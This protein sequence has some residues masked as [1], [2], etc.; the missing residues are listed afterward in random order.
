MQIGLAG[1]T[2]PAG[3]NG[4]NGNN[5]LM[6]CTYLIDSFAN[7]TNTYYR[8]IRGSDSAVSFISAN[9]SYVV[10]S[11]MENLPIAKSNLKE[12]EIDFT[13]GNFTFFS[14]IEIPNGVSPKF[15]GAG[16]EKTILI[17]G[18]DV[19]DALFAYDSSTTVVFPQWRDMTL[20]GNYRNNPCANAYSA[21]IYTNDKILDGLIDNVFIENFQNDSI[22]LGKIWDWRFANVI[23]EYTHSGYAFRTTGIVGSDMK[24]FGGKV[25]YNEKGFSFQSL[26]EVLIDGCWIYGNQENAINIGNGV[27]G[28]TI[29]NSHF[30]GNGLKVK[31]GYADIFAN[32]PTLN[33]KLIGND[34]DG[35]H[36]N[37]TIGW[38]G[39]AIWRD[40]ASTGA[41]IMGNTVQNYA[42][43]P[44]F[45]FSTSAP[46]VGGVVSG[47]PGYNPRG[48]L[49][50]PFSGNSQYI[51]DN[52]DNATVSLGWTYTNSE[53]CKEV[54]ISGGNVTAVTLNG[55]LTG[56][57]SGSFYLA[58]GNTIKI[59]GSLSPTLIFNCC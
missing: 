36:I 9:A 8:A 42:A 3:A 28:L 25:I 26:S 31:T 34:M 29:S 53:S 18:N 49:S 33:L 1:A 54:I 27:T 40:A 22:N 43:N 46:L 20:E 14:R 57:T 30:Y 12:G 41:V 35:S 39:Y 32:Q 16:P 21:A 6:V 50:N 59:E 38:Q 48:I 56:L 37:G 23:V 4:I 15:E 55:H 17:L 19:N 44:Q 13:A 45:R 11:A 51:V 52:G 47:N 24:W 7:E 2:G 5:G 10:I 58:A